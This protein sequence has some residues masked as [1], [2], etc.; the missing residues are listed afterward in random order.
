MDGKRVQFMYMSTQRNSMGMGFGVEPVH[1]AREHLH[2]GHHRRLDDHHIVLE[3]GDAPLEV[4]HLLVGRRL[5]G[6]HGARP[7]ISPPFP[8]S[9]PRA[10]NEHIK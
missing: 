7:R 10:A 9:P 4:G 5:V 6:G 1:E 8:F 2:H 3:V